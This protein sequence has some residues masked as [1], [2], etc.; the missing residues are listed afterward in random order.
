[1]GI[2]VERIGILPS[3]GDTLARGHL[4]TDLYLLKEWII[5]DSGDAIRSA[6]NKLQTR[7]NWRIFSRGHSEVSDGN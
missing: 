3:G 6:E 5:L 1:V 7:E 2:S 4:V